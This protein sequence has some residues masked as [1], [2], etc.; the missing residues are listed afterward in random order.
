MKKMLIVIFGL[1]VMVGVAYSLSIGT[2]CGVL[3]FD[4]DGNNLGQCYIPLDGGLIPVAYQI[5][6]TD[7]TVENFVIYR[8]ADEEGVMQIKL[9]LNSTLTNSNGDR[10]GKNMIFDLT[11]GQKTQIINFIKPFVISAASNY[12]VNPPGW[13]AP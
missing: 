4:V 11:T 5:S 10:E 7:L 3:H 12:D 1:L 8:Q 2:S 6:L 9:A 13:V